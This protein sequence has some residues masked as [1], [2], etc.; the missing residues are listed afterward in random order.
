MEGKG[1]EGENETKLSTWPSLP[2][3]DEVARPR[4]PHPPVGERL[5]GTNEERET[6]QLRFSLGRKDV[7]VSRKEERPKTHLRVSSLRLSQVCEQVLVR[8]QAGDR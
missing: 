3:A 7:E 2:A 8:L 4:R 6:S 5:E 1:K